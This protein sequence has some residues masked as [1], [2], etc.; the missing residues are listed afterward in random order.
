LNLSLLVSL[1]AITRVSST[2]P[3]TPRQQGL[4]GRGIQQRKNLLKRGSKKAANEQSIA[5]LAKELT[6]ILTE[7]PAIQKEQAY[8]E[9][10]RHADV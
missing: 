7:S 9:K 1:F 8:Q 10:E 3:T 2:S 5:S 4:Q 6:S